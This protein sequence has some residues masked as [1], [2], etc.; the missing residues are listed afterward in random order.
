MTRRAF[1]TRN[2]EM[3]RR[4][5]VA[6]G[7]T[8]EMEIRRATFEAAIRLATVLSVVAALAALTLDAVGEVSATRLTLLVAVVGFT[9][10]WIQTGRVSRAVTA[11]STY[12]VA[13][14]PIR[15]SIV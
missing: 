7:Y 15:R 14:M 3:R 5:P 10:S 12:R 11:R 2:C 13:V 1:L 4:A 9:A 8:G 6:S